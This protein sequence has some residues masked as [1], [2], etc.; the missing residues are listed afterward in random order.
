M[1]LNRGNLALGSSAW[2]ACWGIFDFNSIPPTVVQVEVYFRNGEYLFLKRCAGRINYCLD[3]CRLKTSKPLVQ[4]PKRAE[5]ADAVAD[6]VG[7]F[8]TVPDSPSSATA[9]QAEKEE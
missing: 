9:N 3:S 5:M 8:I 6:A 4:T 1:K 7:E 2:D